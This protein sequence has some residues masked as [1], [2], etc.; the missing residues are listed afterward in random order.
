L[1]APLGP[2]SP[3]NEP[4]GTDSR[5]RT[6]VGLGVDR[7]PGRAGRRVGPALGHRHLRR[8]SVGAGPGPRADR[9]WR[10]HDRAGVGAGTVGD[11]HRQA[12]QPTDRDRPVRSVSASSS[13]GWP[14]RC[15]R[16]WR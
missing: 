9:R 11:A 16:S 13:P 2:T 12:G 7:R 8:L 3:K 5:T 6:A 15:C 10:R 4:R 1:P 14:C